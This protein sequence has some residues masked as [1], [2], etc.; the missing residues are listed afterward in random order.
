MKRFLL[1]LAM[2]T[3]AAQ[4]QTAT[5]SAFGKGEGVNGQVNAVAV[6][7]DGKIVIGGKFESV[8]GV[9]RASIARLNTDGTLD[10]TFADTPDAGV[11]GQVFALVI[12]P[13]GGI[14]A[15]GLFTQAGKFQTMNIARYNADGSIDQTFGAGGESQIGANGV[16]FAL[17]VQPDGKTLIGGDFNVVFGQPRRSLARLN[18]DNTLDGPVLSQNSQA[19]GTIRALAANGAA[20]VVGGAFTVLGLHPRNI[21]QIPAPQE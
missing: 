12:Q 3:S 16:V 4:A 18:S 13:N 7:A 20:P 11:N 17:A 8:N 2:F 15:G 19:L 1:V 14:V 5:E 9:P 6:Q 21:L 10:R